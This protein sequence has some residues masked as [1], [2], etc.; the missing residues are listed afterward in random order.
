MRRIA[1]AL[2]D[3]GSTLPLRVA[4]GSPAR[5]VR[6]ML[7]SQLLPALMA[8]ALAPEPRCRAIRLTSSRPRKAAT[9]R[10]MKA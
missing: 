7:V 8:Q 1:G 9:E 10:V 2:A 4:P 3:L 6:P 5:G